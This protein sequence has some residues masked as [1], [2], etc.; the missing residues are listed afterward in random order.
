MRSS[1]RFVGAALVV[2]S[3]GL[4]FA[5]R[6]VTGTMVETTGLLEQ[7]SG[8]ALYASAFYGGVLVLWPRGRPLPVALIS[9]G[10]CWA[11]EFFQL[12]DVPAALSARSVVARLV[13]G[14]VFDPSD[15]VWYVVGV[16]L[17]VAIHYLTLC[18]CTTA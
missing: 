11:V 1:S 16:L 4:A 10:F 3:L 2:G 6:L 13:L 8:T 5:I 12:T 7:V 14:R 9:I 17:A 18:R 15:L